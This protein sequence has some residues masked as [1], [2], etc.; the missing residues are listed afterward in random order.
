MYI[1][2]KN[3]TKKYGS[4]EALVFALKNTSLS[5]EQGEITVILGPS[6]SG[7]STLLNVLGGIDILDQGKYFVHSK[8][9][10][11]LSTGELT[12]YR[13]TNIGFVFQSYNLISD[14]TVEENIQV[15]SDISESPLDIDD[16]LHILELSE[17]KYRFPKEL[18]GG[19]QQ[20][21]AIARAII[22]NPKVLLCDEMTGALDSK[23]SKTV[24]RLIEKVNSQFRTTTVIVTHNEE[25][26]NMADRI[27][28]VKD[29]QIIESVLNKSKVSTEELQL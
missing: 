25:I 4:G 29:G 14:L 7:K 26:K 18:S 13:R 23:S 22:K 2:L 16:V 27:V 15:V 5:I 3:V 21:V 6:G 24:L 1:K 12:E 28:L 19:Q 9:V 20:R 11:S 10:S 17:Y 8:D